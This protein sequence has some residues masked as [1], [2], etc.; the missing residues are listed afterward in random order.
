MSD[1]NPSKWQ[2]NDLNDQAEAVG[3]VKFAQLK[4]LLQP[5][6]R[7]DGQM[8]Y[9]LTPQARAMLKAINAEGEDHDA[10]TDSR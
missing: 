7:P 8:G 10:T 4:G 5:V 6:R 2:E 3:M 9:G 1:K